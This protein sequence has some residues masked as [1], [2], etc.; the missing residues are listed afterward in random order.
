M[1]TRDY[2]LKSE[3]V[4]QKSEM[5]NIVSM[6]DPRK[7]DD[8]QDYKQNVD[9]SQPENT[10]L[11]ERNSVKDKSDLESKEFSKVGTYLNYCEALKASVKSLF[12]YLLNLPIIRLCFSQ[13]PF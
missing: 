12:N 5:V 6:T 4:T 11:D 13:I 7:D 3:K 1:L 9:R 8:K 10:N 2:D